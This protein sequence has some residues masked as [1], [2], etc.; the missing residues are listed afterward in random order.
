MDMQAGIVDHDI[1]MSGLR[2]GLADK[3]LQ[4]AGIPEI[5]CAAGGLTACH[6]NLR[7]HLFQLFPASSSNEDMHTLCCEPGGDGASNAAGCSG[8]DGC[9][10]I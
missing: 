6:F 1:Q 9:F 3:I 5:K 7:F 10:M 4:P 8:N 2:P